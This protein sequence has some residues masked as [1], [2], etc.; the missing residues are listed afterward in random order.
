MGQLV[1]VV[2][3]EVEEAPSELLLGA[4]V[5]TPA[6][7]RRLSAHAVEIGGW[8]LGRE[9]AVSA[10]EVAHGG[11]LL[12]R[13]EVGQ[14][15]SDIEDAY[16]NAEGAGSAGFE[17]EVEAS[18]L[19]ARAALTVRVGIGGATVP[20]ARLR[21]RRYWRGEWDERP[22][23]VSVVVIRDSDDGDL[24]ATMRSLGR[25]RYPL[26]ELVVADSTA[27]GNPAGARN[28]AIRHSEGGLILFLP[29]GAELEA[30]TIANAVGRLAAAAE[31]SA[32]IDGTLGG[33][34]AAAL[35]RRS[36]FEELT[37]FDE[38]AGAGCD[39]ELGGRASEY[40]ALFEPGSLRGGE[41]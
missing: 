9:E 16:P 12:A 22:P 26:T 37:G 39:R 19:P 2:A 7:G 17:I 24:E 40:D 10:V 35:Y 27:E 3:V 5:D 33:E 31:A 18:R 20:V 13:A 41:G 14:P 11:E 1:E 32:L 21:L 34:V 30:N 29:A 8:A 4:S 38:A 23:L 28:E 15:R 36:A 6:A 25:E